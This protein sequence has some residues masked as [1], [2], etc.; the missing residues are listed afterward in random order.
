MFF[1]DFGSQPTKP[2]GITGDIQY[3]NG[4][5]FGGDGGLTYSSAGILEL[6]AGAF[7]S[8]FRLGSTTLPA[9]L[10]LGGVG[11]SVDTITSNS[12]KL[13]LVNLSQ[14]NLNVGTGHIGFDS[15]GNIDLFSGTIQ[16]DVAANGWAGTAVLV[17]GT[18]TVANVNVAANTMIHLTQQT[19]GGT[20][21]F[22]GIASRINGTS[23]TITSSN[24]LDTST[25]AWV[26]FSPNDTVPG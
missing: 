25:I 16:F 17:G 18:V 4:G 13:D 15:T 19:P 21:G 24:A 26:M 5:V 9:N 22:V 8:T 11:A 2:G 7:Q 3:N 23:F 10:Q 12:N 6:N 14:I 1:V 20:P